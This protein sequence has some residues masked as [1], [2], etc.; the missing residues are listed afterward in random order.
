M[1]S[2]Q[3]DPWTH[4]KKWWDHLLEIGPS[5]VYY[6]QPTKSWLI[7]KPDQLE[8]A[9][10]KFAG[11]SKIKI[12][13]DGE[14]HLGAV[15]GMD[16]NKVSTVQYIN[17]KIDKWTPEINLLAE[18]AATYPQAAYSVYVSSYQHKLTYFLC[19]IPT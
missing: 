10:E 13:S 7:V 4:L 5:Y 3:L 11:T 8:Q 19:T 12:R 1:I 6:P 17:Q 15:I 2:Q 14:L 9:Q 18:I 16:E